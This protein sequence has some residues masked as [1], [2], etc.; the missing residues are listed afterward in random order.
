MRALGLFNRMTARGREE[1]S[2]CTR[3]NKTA[4]PWGGTVSTSASLDALL[5][6]LQLVPWGQRA[7]SVSIP[8]VSPQCWGQNPEKAAGKAGPGLCGHV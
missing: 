4:L 5:L 8:G 6:T 2:A 7:R 1:A 3:V